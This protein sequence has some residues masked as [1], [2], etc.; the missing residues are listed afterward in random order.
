MPFRV[1]IQHRTRVLW[2]AC[3]SQRAVCGCA[4]ASVY[5]LILMSRPAAPPPSSYRQYMES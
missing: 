4:L 3:R 1:W 5:F 2:E